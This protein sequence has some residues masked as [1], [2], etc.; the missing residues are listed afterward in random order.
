M[1]GR[2]WFLIAAAALSFLLCLSAFAADPVFG[3]LPA[4]QILFHQDYSEI[5]SLAETGVKLGTLT[6]ENAQLDLSAGELRVRAPG[7][8]R[9][10]LLLPEIA[11]GASYT[12]E[13]TFR[14]TESGHENGSLACLLTCRGEE[15]T[16]ITAVVIRGDG[17]IDDFTVPGEL[18]AAIRNGSSVTV[19]I[20]VEEGSLHLMTVSAGGETYELER[21]TVQMIPPGGF[22]FSFRNIAA[23]VSEVWVVNGCGYGEKT[24]DASSFT[25]EAAPAEE[26][27]P[28]DPEKTGEADAPDAPDAP[29]LPPAVVEEA[30]TSPA[31]P[32]EDEPAA[33]PETGDSAQRAGAVLVPAALTGALGMLCCALP[34]KKKRANRKTR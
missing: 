33:A 18:S 13:F 24:G 8:G 6:Q 9:T 14:I 29:D 31:E 12:V 11:H 10:Y 27:P 3:E 2:A 26:E 5:E 7:S 15:P 30:E 16:N 22:G 20:P 21:S 17:T 28:E 1:R 32:Q 23:D 19:K 34:G 25:V 4:G